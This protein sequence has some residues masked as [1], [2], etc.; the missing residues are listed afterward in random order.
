MNKIPL[1]LCALLFS[2]CSVAQNV[3]IKRDNKLVGLAQLRNIKIHQ[4]ISSKINTGVDSVSIITDVDSLYKSGDTLYVRP[5][6]TEEKQAFDSTVNVTIQKIYNPRSKTQ[7]KIPIKEIDVLTGKRRSLSRLFSFVSTA[8]FI[9]VATSIPLRLSDPNYQAI[10]NTIFV[11]AA[12][13]LI[14]SWT[15]QAT[16]AKKRYHFDKSRTDKN[17]WNFN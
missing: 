3:F 5:W 9:S 6:I 13:T 2:F 1:F 10:G 7:I 8:A 15:L 4:N 12:P 16:V 14:V 17:I 11:I